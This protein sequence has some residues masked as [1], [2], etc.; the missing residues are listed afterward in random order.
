M[1][2]NKRNQFDVQLISIDTALF[3]TADVIIIKILWNKNE[4]GF[5]TECLRQSIT[6]LVTIF[7]WV[8]TEK[9][10]KTKWDD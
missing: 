3:L 6:T 2:L 10:I 7:V 8:A 4:G 9:K 5:Q 1:S